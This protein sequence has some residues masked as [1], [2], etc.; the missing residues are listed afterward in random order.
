MP[1][2]WVSNL[3]ESESRNALGGILRSVNCLMVNNPGNNAESLYKL[4][5][6]TTAHQVGLDVPETIVTSKP[7]VTR[8]FYDR[9]NGQVIYKFIGE[10]TKSFT[11]RDMSSLQEFPPYLVVLRM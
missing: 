1:E 6:L 11:F 5:Q 4:P 9:M 7:E 3:I 10:N 2:A 8:D